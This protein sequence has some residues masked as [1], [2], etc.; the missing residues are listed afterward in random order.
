MLNVWKTFGRASVYR[1]QFTKLNKQVV[2]VTPVFVNVR[3]LTYRSVR[4]VGREHLFQTTRNFH[5]TQVKHLHPLL[6]TI[7]RPLAKFSAMLVGR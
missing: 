6:W 7:I 5:T 4:R 2:N 3:I 1:L